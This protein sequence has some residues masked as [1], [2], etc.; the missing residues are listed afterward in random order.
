MAHEVEGHRRHLF[1]IGGWI[2]EEEQVGNGTRSG[3]TSWHWLTTKFPRTP[4]HQHRSCWLSCFLH[5]WRL[6]EDTLL[7][8]LGHLSA[9]APY[10]HPS[11]LGLWTKGAQ[12]LLFRLWGR[13]ATRQF[14]SPHAL[15]GYKD[16]GPQVNFLQLQMVLAPR[17]SFQGTV[18]AVYM[19][20]YVV[21]RV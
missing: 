13:G 20:S 10:P 11:A 17:W 3:S 6:S 16:R 19:L 9:P 14:F 4:T 5:A 7:V 21:Q 8:G 15:P 2:C 1:K 18:E 12:T